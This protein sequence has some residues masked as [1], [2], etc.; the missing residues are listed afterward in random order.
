MVSS[1]QDFNEE[2]DLPVQVFNPNAEEYIEGKIPSDVWVTA[3]NRN[4]NKFSNIIAVKETAENPT[5][6]FQGIRKFSERFGFCYSK[7][8]NTIRKIEQ[9]STRRRT[10]IVEKTVPDNQIFLVYL[11]SDWEIFEWR[12]GIREDSSLRPENHGDRF[13]EELWKNSS[14]SK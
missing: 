7:N 4:P 13:E 6:I 5:Y 8:I 9:D 10:K 14:K 3:K 12:L 2:D 11:N 1:Y